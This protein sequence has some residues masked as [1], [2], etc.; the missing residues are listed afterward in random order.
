MNVIVK[1]E[2]PTHVYKR[3]AFFITFFAAAFFSTKVVGQG[4][5]L[6]TP[7]RIVFD[8]QKRMQEL[9][10]ANAGKDTAKYL[11]SFMEIR[12]KSDGT[13][14]PINTPDS[15]QHFAS[16][17]LRLFPR[18]VTLAP[19]EAQL[20]KIQVVKTNEL[21]PGEYRSHI[22]FRAVPDLKPLGEKSPTN[23]SIGISVRLTPIFGLT[24]PVII[25][26]GET[27]ASVKITDL[28]IIPDEN[29][30]S[31]LSLVFNRTGNSSVYG[32][33]TVDYISP[34]GT[35]TQAGV[36]NGIAVYTPTTSRR[37]VI[38]LSNNAAID[39][40]AGKLHVAYTTPVDAKSIKI[41][42]AEIV[43]H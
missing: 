19:N 16:S 27:S 1:R 25:R 6:V 12:M 40:K 39:Y 4:N 41:A 9:N 14:E 43:L 35:V 29:S 24:V 8:G 32:D 26:V 33:L 38:K 7:R 15:G 21:V 11:I 28:S 3:W 13:F 36:V 30:A 37:M 31:Q 2:H 42:E 34:K 10:L 5:L 17:Y 23:D 20:V 18:T 22:Y